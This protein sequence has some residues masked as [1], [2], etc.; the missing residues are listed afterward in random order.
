MMELTDKERK[1]VDG[2]AKQNF[3]VFG[4]EFMWIKN[5]AL[6][7]NSDNSSRVESVDF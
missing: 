1:Q 5:R 2:Y 3:K 4:Q 6:S 7:P